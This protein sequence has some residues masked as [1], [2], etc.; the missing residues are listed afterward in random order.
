MITYEAAPCHIKVKW[1]RGDSKARAK[2]LGRIYTD[3]K[4]WWYVPRGCS[5]EYASVK[6]PSL[7]LLKADLEN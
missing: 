7:E 1:K 6:W 3:S 4:L 5:M 2:E